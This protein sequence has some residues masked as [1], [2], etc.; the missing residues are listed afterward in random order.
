MGWMP[1]VGTGLGRPISIPDPTHPSV[2]WEASWEPGL[3]KP[4]DVRPCL[5]GGK[6]GWLSQ[7]LS[8]PTQALPCPHPGA[9][10]LLTGDPGTVEPPCH[11]PAGWGR[12]W[13][14]VRGLLGQGPLLPGPALLLT[15]EVECINGPRSSIL[16]VTRTSASGAASQ[17]ASHAAASHGGSSMAG[18]EDRK[19]SRLRQRTLSAQKCSCARGHGPRGLNP[20]QDPHSPERVSGRCWRMSQRRDQLPQR[21]SRFTQGLFRSGVKS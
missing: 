18:A 4:E 8:H 5:S 19:T 11:R 3:L 15:K 12:A 20:G 7:C 16:T 9:H 6:V 10:G 1:S 14:W 21:A 17:V 2:S 13:G